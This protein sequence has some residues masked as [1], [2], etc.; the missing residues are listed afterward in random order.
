MAYYRQKRIPE[1]G[2]RIDVSKHRTEDEILVASNSNYVVLVANVEPGSLEGVKR[3]GKEFKPTTLN[4]IIGFEK[5]MAL[6]RSLW[7]DLEYLA[8]YVKDSHRVVCLAYPN[9]DVVPVRE[10]KSQ[11][12]TLQN[13]FVIRD[14]LNFL[15]ESNGSAKLVSA[16]CYDSDA[17]FSIQFTFQVLEVEIGGKNHFFEQHA[18]LFTSHDSSQAYGMAFGKIGKSD[19]FYSTWDT[20]KMKHTIKIQTHID[21]VKNFLNGCES[22]G[23][24]FIAQVSYLGKIELD[25]NSI[26]YRELVDQFVISHKENEKFSYDRRSWEAG[27]ITEYFSK[28]SKIYG[29]NAWAFHT[30]LSEY[31]FSH[32]HK[33]TFETT[34]TDLRESHFELQNRLKAILLPP[35]LISS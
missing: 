28:A 12:T 32:L 31:A 4:N 33:A 21:K 23:E 1:L 14:A 16:G 5:P 17:L 13:R 24:S 34:S 11:Y 2:T 30:A 15:E 35:Q 8:D 10:V 18:T 25:P 19:P 29:L 26:S 27:K 6:E 7:P 20:L 3:Y 22:A 9:G